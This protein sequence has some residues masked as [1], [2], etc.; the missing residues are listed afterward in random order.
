MATWFD[1]VNVDCADAEALAQW[2]AA[3]LDWPIA[4]HEWTDGRRMTFEFSIDPPPGRPG[5]SLTFANVVEHKV[6]FN[7]VH[8]DL[9][10]GS[11]S[12]QASLVT[13]LERRGARRIDIGQGDVP[14][15]VLADTEGNEFC[16]LDPRDDYEHTGQIAA[17]VMKAIDPIALA[18]FWSAA[19]GW[20]V[21]VSTPGYAALKAE[22]QPGPLLELIA[23]NE[24]H[25][26]K[27]RWHLDV[28]PD[29]GSDQDIEVGRLLD[30]GAT[31]AEVGQ[32]NAAPGEVT[33]V[34]LADPEG[35]EF[36]V[37]RGIDQ[38]K[39]ERS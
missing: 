28:R 5:V 13:A 24:P 11:D 16:V 17:I 36:C 27:N 6:G 39:G 12:E 19:T 23:T 8:V 2:W 38:P 22:R 26:V 3:T 34:V 30:L 10:S 29:T 33:W 4:R 37:L 18:P 25:R 32:A 20:D 35:N 9:R 15:V 14:F 1:S 7:R 31:K 21:V